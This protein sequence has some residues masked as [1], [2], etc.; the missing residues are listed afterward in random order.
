MLRSEYFDRL[1]EASHIDLYL[2]AGGGSGGRVNWPWKMT[3]PKESMQRI[4]DGCDS[5]VIDSDPLDDEVTTEDV[6]DCALEY[7]ADIASLQD[8]YQ[9]KDATVDSILKGIETADSHT[10]DGNLLLPLQ[11]PFTECYREIG[12][13]TEYM[14][15]LGGLKDAKAQERIQS[16]R[17]FRDSFGYE[18]HIHGFGWGLSD[19]LSLFIRENPDQ[20]D[21]VDYSTPVQ[22]AMNSID[23]SR[24]EEMSSVL[25]MEM[26]AILVRDLREVGSFPTT[27]KERQATF[28][29]F[30]VQ[31]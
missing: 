8:V 10:F 24:G 12:E 26:S 19:R 20:I 15:G 17:K 22:M 27:D 7:N 5:Y 2:S 14:I 21:S 1:V 3:P 30:E 16:V 25:A 9:N 28:G 4:R 11:K 18:T 13:P 23:Y 29:K 31:T 6:L